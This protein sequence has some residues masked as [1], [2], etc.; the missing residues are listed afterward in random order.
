MVSL[1]G[2]NI[3]F[4]A[5]AFLSAVWV[6]VLGLWII[7]K[8]SSK[9]STNS[10][11]DKIGIN[12]PIN[13]SK[14]KYS[15]FY[16]QNISNLFHEDSILSKIG[17]IIVPDSNEV[18]R[19]L[20]AADVQM[21]A[22]EFVS[23]KVLLLVVGGAIGLF[24]L[25]VNNNM[26]LV[27]GILGI[28]LSFLLDNQIYGD[29]LKKRKEAMQSDLPNFLDMLYSACRTGHT[30]PKAIEKVSAKYPGVVSDE[31]NRAMVE[32]KSNGGNFVEAMES[33]VA[34][35]D[36]PELTNCVSNIVIAYQKGDGDIVNVVKQEAESIRINST[37]K[38]K[39]MVGRKQ[40]TLLLPMM[41]FFLIPIMAMILLPFLSQI[42]A[43]M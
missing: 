10:I 8:I 12:T 23:I 40:N 2:F 26:V 25:I 32:C 1:L 19:K 13:N 5:I 20:K 16:Q 42:L 30:V 21:T 17:K 43:I 36:M 27:I 29:K 41:V 4:K 24:G 35:N 39:E 22:E 37:L 3:S 11:K 14:N 18:A 7:S 33:L 28:V 6:V 34:R 38:F 15:D 31:F 9:Y